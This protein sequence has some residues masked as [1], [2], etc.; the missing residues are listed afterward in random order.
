MVVESLKSAEL[1]ILLQEVVDDVEGQDGELLLFDCD[2][3]VGQ[4][5]GLLHRLKCETVLN[6]VL[7]HPT[8]RA[9]EEDLVHIG[10]FSS[11]HDAV[12]HRASLHDDVQV[13]AQDALLPTSLL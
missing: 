7:E 11:G 3:L 5:C 2:N 9:Q 13:A 12:H 10:I 6:S 8:D 1:P 4:V